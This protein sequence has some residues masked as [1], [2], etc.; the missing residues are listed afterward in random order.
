MTTRDPRTRLLKALFLLAQSSEIINI[1]TLSEH[2]GLSCY[3]VL[4]ALSELAEHG[5]ASARRMRLTMAGLTLT[6]ALH[7]ELRSSLAGST[8]SGSLSDGNV[9][10]GSS[11]GSAVTVPWLKAVA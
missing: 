10:G 6:V 9:F 5:L 8:L 2:T 7:P 1:F 11:F 3:A 4:K